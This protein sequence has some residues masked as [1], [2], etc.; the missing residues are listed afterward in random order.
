MLFRGPSEM[1]KVADASP[2]AHVPATPRPSGNCTSRSAHSGSEIG[3]TQPN[4][5]PCLPV[6]SLLHSPGNV[7]LVWTFG[8]VFIVT[9]LSCPD[10]WIPEVAADGLFL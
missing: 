6:C 9:Y 2:T 10:H 1:C 7:S 3:L 5:G 8:Y 4:L